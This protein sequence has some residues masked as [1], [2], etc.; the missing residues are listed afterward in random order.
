M[1]SRAWQA[2]VVAAFL[3]AAGSAVGDVV[4]MT[5]GQRLEGRVETLDKKPDRVRF[6][7]GVGSMELSRGSI[8][9]IIEEPD[10]VDW[11]R[12]GLQL[13]E[14]KSY[15]RGIETLQQA[16]AIDPNDADAKRGIERAQEAMSTARRE[17]ERVSAQKIERDIEESRRLLKDERFAE[18][19]SL[20]K[21]LSAAALTDAQ[22]TAAQGALV[23]LYTA[24]GFQRLDRLDPK[25]AEAH[26]ARVLELDPDNAN[27]RDRLLE[28]WKNDPARKADVLKAY[29]QKLATDPDNLDL[30]MQVADSL[31]MMNRLEEAIPALEKLAP[32]PKYR[33]LRYDAR[34]RS[35][36]REV[37][38]TQQEVGNYDAAISNT[39]KLLKYFPGEDSSQLVILRYRKNVA[40]SD[41]TD[42]DARARLIKGLR[43]AGLK[44]LAADE[45]AIVS[46]LAP[47]NEILMAILREEAEERLADVRETLNRREFAVARDMARRYIEMYSDQPDLAAK[48][49]E[50]YERA[51]IEAERLARETRQQARE[52]AQRGT[53]YYQQALAFAEQLR[54]T[55]VNQGARPYSAKQEAIKFARRAID[56]LTTA[57]N[58]DPSL[59]P[60]TGMDLNAR[61][62][63]ARQL[64]TTLTQ[65]GGGLERYRYTTNKG[66]DSTR[67]IN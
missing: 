36:L 42:T 41:P 34:L 55:E 30:N 40:T 45:A 27:A 10:A 16:L 63:D 64:L 51:N 17:E 1:R 48:A 37:I 57:V 58:M 47:K 13:V 2:T 23:E 53:E 43:D 44:E 38:R 46:R 52:I 14:A 18:A 33:A 49:S 20:L 11:R 5:N 50:M 32:A 24:W 3:A 19:E 6:I 9:E 65:S 12:I 28:V 60:I 39:E 29:Q 54:S 8:R 61:L 26:Y 67:T 22:R 25:G 59:G 66:V 21:K 31:L 7:R 15:Q 4:V 56:S 35:T 62:G